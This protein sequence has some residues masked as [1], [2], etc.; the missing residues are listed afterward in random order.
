MEDRVLLEQYLRGGSD[1]AFA[2][3]TRR[4]QDWV[5]A[6]ALRQVR[7]PHLASDVTQ[8]V[9]V[10]VARKAAALLSERVPAGGLCR[11]THFESLKVLREGRRRATREE[12][13][14]SGDVRSARTDSENAIAQ[15]LDDA[16]ARLRAKDRDLIV[17]RF[18]QNKSLKDVAQSFAISEDAAQKRLERALGKLRKKLRRHDVATS[19]LAVLLASHSLAAA[20]ANLS[21][22]VAAALASSS[23]IT[24]PAVHAGFAGI[25]LM[26]KAKVAAAAVAVAGLTAA[27]FVVHHLSNESLRRQRVE[28]EAQHQMEL[29]RARARLLADARSPDRS[30]EIAALQ[31]QIADLHHEL[32]KRDARQSRPAA[33]LPESDSLASIKQRAINPQNSPEDRVEALRQLR[34]RNGRDPQVAAAMATLARTSLD[35]RIRADIFRQLSG[36]VEPTLKRVML[37]ALKQDPVPEVRAEAAETLAAYQNDPEVSSQLAATSRGDADIEVREQ[38]AE[39]MLRHAP[40][41]ALQKVLQHPDSTPVE[42]YHSTDRLRKLQGPNSEQAHALVKVLHGPAAPKLR[43][44]AVEDLG[45]HYASV[46]GVTEW[47][48]HLARS[49][50]DPKV[51]RKANEF[52]SEGKR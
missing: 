13:F 2:E 36:V 11:A 30:G 37:D 52:L 9:F 25:F 32:A 22:S 17:L 46:P 41:D 45:R 50:S 20:P 12:L 3:F 24:A 31:Q 8:N 35:P 14:A 10:C 23:A 51:Q 42:L 27:P 28:L 29:D 18:M 15:E 33:N 48:Q 39:A 1:H 5:Y 49:D 34:D 6:I 21:S 43:E 16:L 47:L 26:T 44:D 7:D 38:A 4:Y 19:S 40:A